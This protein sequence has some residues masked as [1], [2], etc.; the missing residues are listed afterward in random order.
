ML[1]TCPDTTS[2]GV[3]DSSEED[4][5]QTD[6]PACRIAYSHAEVGRFNLISNGLAITCN[7]LIKYFAR[8]FVSWTYGNEFFN[9]IPVDSQYVLNA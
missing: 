3:M 8:P 9:C 1:G 5:R 4:L 6:V 2:V 7:L